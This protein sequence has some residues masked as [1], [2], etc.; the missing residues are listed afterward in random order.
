M[1]RTKLFAQCLSML[2][3]AGAVSLAVADEN[4][5]AAPEG[6]PQLPHGWTMED[7][8]KVIAAGTPGKEHAH[9]VEGA[10]AWKADTCMWMAPDAEPIKSS[11]TST[12]TFLSTLT[13]PLP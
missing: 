8:Q 2:A 3:L 1:K 6:A 7:M 13:M 10:G 11:G 9:L 4:T 12:D 5:A